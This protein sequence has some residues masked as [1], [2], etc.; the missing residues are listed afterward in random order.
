MKMNEFEQ[1]HKHKG[2]II[3]KGKALGVVTQECQFQAYPWSFLDLNY[4]ELRKLAR[5]VKKIKKK[6]KI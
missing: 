3:H 5:V 4:K 1:P 6:E 2:D